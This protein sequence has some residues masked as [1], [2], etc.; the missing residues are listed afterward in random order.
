MNHNKAWLRILVLFI[1]IAGCSPSGKEVAEDTEKAD[2]PDEI[3]FSGKIMADTAASMV[4]WVGRKTT[5]EH[6][7]YFR[8][9]EGEFSIHG[10]MISSGKVVVDVT[11]IICSDIEDPSENKDLTDHL[12]DPDFLNA[13][14]FPEAIFSVTSVKR[15]ASGNASDISGDL[16]IKDISHAVTFPAVVTYDSASVTLDGIIE[17]DRTW[18]GMNYKSKTIFP[19]LG[20]KFIHDKVELNIH[21]IGRP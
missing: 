2:K 3:P 1:G 18:Y 13:Q 8:I 10:G 6:R 15:A 21:L 5:G 12:L 11:S 4:E 16:I 17:F 14:K 9:K 7:G 20:N 19:D